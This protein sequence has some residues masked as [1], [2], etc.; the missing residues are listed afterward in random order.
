MGDEDPKKI[1]AGCESRTSRIYTETGII[2]TGA[3]TTRPNLLNVRYASIMI[4]INE[5]W[6]RFRRF[7]KV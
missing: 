7:G 5:G 3:L 2:G 1:N 6:R 4:H